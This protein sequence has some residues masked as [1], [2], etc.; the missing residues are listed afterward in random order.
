MSEPDG[1]EEREHEAME[2]HDAAMLDIELSE[3]RA[4]ESLSEVLIDIA[5]TRITNFVRYL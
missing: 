1:P 3:Q 5:R 4:D 2:R